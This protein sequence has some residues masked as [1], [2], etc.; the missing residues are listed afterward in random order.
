MI[1]LQPL[2]GRRHRRRQAVRVAFASW[3]GALVIAGVAW[4]QATVGGSGQFGPPVPGTEAAVTPRTGLGV[5]PADLDRSTPARAWRAFV[6]A[7][8]ARNF[9]RA[10]WLL[11]LGDVAADQARLVGPTR[12]AKLWRVLRTARVAEARDLPDE[13][14]PSPQ[15]GGT[16][17][18]WEVARFR[19]AATA[20]DV[21]IVLERSITPDDGALA[22]RISSDTVSSIA[23]W[24]ARIVDGDLQAVTA[25]ELN[26]G[27]GPRPPDLDLSTPA[28]SLKSL[29]E[30]TRAGRLDVAARSLW[31]NDIPEQQQAE[32]GRKLARELMMV[33]DQTLWIDFAA[34][35]DRPFGKPES[36]E[37][38]DDEDE[39]GVVPLGSQKLPIRLVRVPEGREPALW[40]VSR[41]TVTRIPALYA[42]YGIGDLVTWIPAPL[43]AHRFL[44]IQAWQWLGLG[45]ALVLALGVGVLARR[46]VL[47]IT[48]LIASRWPTLA[49]APFAE[50]IGA[51]MQSIFALVAVSWLSRWLR[52][53]KPAVATLED[54]LVP[55][56][57]GLVTWLVMRASELVTSSIERYLAAAS[58]E[59]SLQ[60]SVSTRLQLVRRLF[61]VLVLLIATAAVLMRFEVVRHIGTG[62]LASAGFAGIVIGFAAQQTLGNLFTGLL[63]GIT[64]PV[65]IGDIVVFEGEWGFVEEISLTHVVICTWDLRRLVVPI[66]YL[67]ARPIQNWTR[68]SSEVLGTVVVKTSASVDVDALRAEA[69]R[70]VKGSKLSDGKEPNVSVA[71]FSDTSVEIR[72]VVG[73]SNAAQLWALRS[74]VREAM[75][76]W[77]QGQRRAEAAARTAG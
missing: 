50:L 75:L 4:G 77:V 58:A 72:I 12:A 44:E 31:L 26:R 42:A 38:A 57:I 20:T 74:E 51:P 25:D 55:L 69:V 39:I 28:R 16:A 59:S 65:R 9:E 5:A 67:L 10:A 52:L 29:V 34:V 49:R 7:A 63:F 18:R 45:L 43:F 47:G 56:T 3:L 2:A 21:A 11:D 27:L 35:S 1:A 76:R 66:P 46:A 48:G 13:I 60:R 17:G 41:A 33:L 62:L 6:D 30:A 37:I 24:Y 54:L 32:V 36:S 22:W 73:A 14:D 61:N 40:V 19:H 70:V 71:D 68:S 8:G 64:Q 15:P 53:S 23:H